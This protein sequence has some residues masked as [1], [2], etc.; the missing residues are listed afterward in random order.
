MDVTN[1]L[2]VVS[3]VDIN[4][5]YSTLIDAWLKDSDAMGVIDVDMNDVSILTR[6][7]KL[8][9]SAKRGRE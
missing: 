5:I 6:G 4:S 7:R 9:P 3:N 8:V 1:Q 2:S